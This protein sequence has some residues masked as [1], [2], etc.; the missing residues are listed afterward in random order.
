MAGTM[1]AGALVTKGIMDKIDKQIEEIDK[2]LHRYD[3]YTASKSSTSNSITHQ[4]IDQSDLMRRTLGNIGDN[5]QFGPIPSLNTRGNCQ[6]TQSNG[7]C[8]SASRAVQSFISDSGQPSVL[9]QTAAATGELSDSLNNGSITGANLNQAVNLGKQL[10]R[11]TKMRKAIE[12]QLPNQNLL[13]SANKPIGHFESFFNANTNSRIKKVLG[14]KLNDPNLGPLLAATPSSGNANNKIDVLETLASLSPNTLPASSAGSAAAAPQGM[15][16]NFDSG[17]A[18]NN[19][20]INESN[21]MAASYDYAEGRN[22]VNNNKD[23][24]IFDILSHR[25]LKTAYPILFNKQ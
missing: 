15:K 2:I 6:L 3:G 21:E 23:S 25:Y 24:S 12:S 14:A 4:N 1:A 13:L 22:Q 9:S 7:N 18:N 16:F 5:E 19:E 10:S 20:M 17:N 11:L 8:L